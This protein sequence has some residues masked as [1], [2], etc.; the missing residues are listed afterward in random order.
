LRPTLG[1]VPGRRI[2]VVG[3]G[4]TGLATAVLAA[5]RGHPVTLV[6]RD[7]L[8]AGPM[9]QSPA[10]PRP[11]VPH[12]LQ[13]H[14]FIPRARLELRHHLPDVYSALVAGGA[15]EVDLRAKLP[16]PVR[17]EDAEL[18]YLAVRRPLIEW[19][20][21]RAV[22]AERGI[23]VRAGGRARGFVVDEGTVT[24]VRL[25]D[26]LVAADLV[27]DAHGRRT[28]TNGWLA[29]AGVDAAEPA[30]TS[31]G[32][33]YYSRYYR[34]RPGF[35]LPDGPWFLSPRGDLGYLA[36][37]SFPGD[38][39]TFAGLLATPP[40]NPDWRILGRPRAFE[41]AVARIPALA[42]WADPAGVEPITDVLPM[43]GLRNSFTDRPSPA[44][45]LLLAGDAYCHTDPT[46]A[47]GLAFGLVHAAAAVSALD[48][49]ADPVDLAD[50]YAVATQPELR[51]RFEWASALDDQR[52]RNWLGEPVDL[53]HHDGDYA[54]FSQA[55]AGAVARVDPEVFRVF[56]RRIGLLDRTGV[57]DGDLGLRR[58]IEATFADLRARPGPPLGP[59]RD[60]LLAAAR[61]AA[62]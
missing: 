44:P 32:V 23:D 1:A 48:E 49:H 7:V 56:N 51:E 57:L 37:A 6:E 38:N 61:A 22:A 45:G 59:P 33:V 2:V 46:L 36:F 26:G 18:V 53:A 10:L 42:S 25:D 8:P 27:V 52:L 15:S 29:A 4:V 19:A 58:R 55:A 14:A 28:V 47:H 43:A 41:A 34:C 5:R 39:R 24:G 17:A 40:G 30:V 20:L 60:E 12:Y 3:G 35:E 16:G 13:P 62:G 31:C 21:R 11:G 50:A 9:S 54:L